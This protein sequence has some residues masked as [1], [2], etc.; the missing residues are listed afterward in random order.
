MKLDILDGSKVYKSPPNLH[1]TTFYIGDNPH[2]E[3]SDYFKNFT[4][5]LP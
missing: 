3:D 1:I 4:P 5:D 2:P